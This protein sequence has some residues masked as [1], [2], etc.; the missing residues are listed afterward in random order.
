MHTLD[1]DLC[2]IIWLQF[3]SAGNEASMPAPWNEILTVQSYRRPTQMAKTWNRKW[4]AN[5]TFVSNSNKHLINRLNTMLKGA[6]FQAPTGCQWQT[7]ETPWNQ[8]LRFRSSFARTLTTGKKIWFIPSLHIGK[9]PSNAGRKI[10][11]CTLHLFS[12][13]MKSPF[14]TIFARFRHLNMD[15][16]WHLKIFKTFWPW[17]YE[18]CLQLK[19]LICT[20][21]VSRLWES[22]YAICKS[23]W[24][25]IPCLH[26]ARSILEPVFV[27]HR[28]WSAVFRAI[29]N[30]LP[31]VSYRIY[32][33]LVR[34]YLGITFCWFR[35][36]CQVGLVA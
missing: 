22:I 34:V 5:A 6:T 9:N 29:C 19:T 27:L 26:R 2:M 10:E 35:V 3:T 12:T 13:D 30:I 7:L 31:G 15:F 36:F 23:F 21:F 32:F 24:P 20:K 1:R 17:I 16:T 14:S 11:I 8:L 4:N 28:I 25:W 18:F 33:S